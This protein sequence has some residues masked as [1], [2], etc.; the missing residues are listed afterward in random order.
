MSLLLSLNTKKLINKRTI[1]TMIVPY[2]PLPIIPSMIVLVWDVFTPPKKI[3]ENKPAMMETA[4]Y[5]NTTRNAD[6]AVNFN[7]MSSVV[8]NIYGKYL[9]NL[10]HDNKEDQNLQGC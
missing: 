3:A 10:R 8:K 4:M 6:L 5:K 1:I 2:M 9:K 7:F